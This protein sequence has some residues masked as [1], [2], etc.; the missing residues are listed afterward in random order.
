MFHNFLGIDVRPDKLFLR[1]SPHCTLYFAYQEII[2]DRN[3]IGYS[4]LEIGLSIYMEGSCIYHY[5]F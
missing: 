1:L 4:L 2:H 3:G 5:R